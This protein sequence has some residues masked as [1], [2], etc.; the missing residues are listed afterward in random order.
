MRLLC[1]LLLV[2]TTTLAGCGGSGAGGGS[3][4]SGS[5]PVGDGLQLKWPPVNLSGSQ[6][7]GATPGSVDVAWQ[8]NAYI[9][10]SQTGAMFSHT[11]TAVDAFS[12]QIAIQPA[13]PTDAGTFTGTITVNACFND[14]SS[15]CHHVPGSPKTIGVTYNVVGLSV[16]PAQLSFS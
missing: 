13:Y 15:A 6:I 10:T 16:T 7:W 14:S 11:F 8:S 4:G 5:S 1:A 2:A 3:G 9:T 12:G